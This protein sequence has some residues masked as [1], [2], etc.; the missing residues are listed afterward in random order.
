M[1]A[2]QR[3]RIAGLADSG[4]ALGVRIIAWSLLAASLQASGH[5]LPIHTGSPSPQASALAS[6]GS[7]ACDASSVVQARMLGDARYQRGDY[8]GAGACYRA[9]GRY[10]LANQADLKAL[11][12]E[13][14]AAARAWAQTQDAAKAQIHQ[15]QLAFRRK[16]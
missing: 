5:D 4:R 14:A 10:D 12:P 3:S 13:S 2:V 15:L 1:I 8:R 7:R 6:D 11:R 16:R 9:A